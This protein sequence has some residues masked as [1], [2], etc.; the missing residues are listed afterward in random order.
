MKSEVFNKIILAGMSVALLQ[1]SVSC[2]QLDLVETP[3]E[4]MKYELNIQGVINQEYQTRANDEGFVNGDRMGVYVV[5]YEQGVPGA[6]MAEGNRANNMCYTYDGESGNWI[7]AGTLYW[8]D[9][10]TPVDVYGYYP[11]VNVVSSV[12]EYE[13]EVNYN[14]NL[15]ADYGDMSSYEASD[16]LWAKTSGAVY[17]RPI[18]LTYDH[19]MAGVQVVLEKGEGFTD[20]EWIKHT[21][22]ISVDNTIRGSVIDLSS[23]EVKAIGDFDR[24]II[25]SDEGTSYR[26]IVVPQTVAAGKSIIGLTIDGISYN[27]KKEVP[28]TYTSGKLHK[29]TIKVDKRVESGDYMFSLSDEQVLPWEN[30]KSSHNFESRAYVVVHLEKEGTLRQC[31]IDSGADWTTIKNLKI[32]G[33]MTASDFGFINGEMRQLEAINIRDV[34]VFKCDVTAT[35]GREILVDNALP[36]NCFQNMNLLRSVILPTNLEKI[37]G[38]SFSYLRFAT[39][40]VIPDGVREIWEWAFSGFSGELVMPNS[41][42]HIHNGAFSSCQAHTNLVLPPTLKYVGQRAFNNAHGFYGTF[43]LPSSLEYVGPEAFRGCGTDLE[44]SVVIPEKIVSI[45]SQAFCARFKNKTTVTLHSGVKRI[46]G[47]AFAGMGIRTVPVFHE[48]LEYIGDKAFNECYGM[49]GTISFPSTLGY[50]GNGAFAFADLSGVFEIPDHLPIIYSSE[51]RGTFSGNDFSEI[52]STTELLHIGDAAF[53]NNGQLRKVF[54][55]RNVEFIGSKAFS[56]CN[57]IHTFICLAKEP[58]MLG[59]ETFSGLDFEHAILEVPAASV[60][61]YRNTPGWNDFKYITAYHELA[62]GISEITALNAGVER[63]TVLRAEGPWEVLSCPDWCTVT[64]MSGDTKEDIIIRVKDMALGSGDRQGQIVFTLKNKDYTN[65]TSVRQFDYATPE[66]TEVVL[67]EA[68]AGA[69]EIP[70]FILGDGFGAESIKDGSYM[71]IMREQIEHFFNIEPYRTYRNYFT[72]STSIAHSPENGLSTI[73]AL[74]DSR[75]GTVDVN[76]NIS[77]DRNALYDYV[78][79]VSAHIDDRNLQKSLIILMVNDEQ[80]AANVSIE[81]NGTTICFCPLSNESYPYDQRGIIQHYAGGRGFGKLAHEDI[82][83]YDFMQLCSCPGCNKL[84][85]Y[86]WAKERGWYDNVSLSG[87]MSD[88]PWSHLI[89]HEKYSQMVDVY[90]GGLGHARGVF[91]SEINSCMNTFVPYYNTISRESIVRRIMNYAGVEYRFED[92]VARDVVENYQ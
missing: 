64:P 90:E 68:T 3:S 78:K 57:A 41:L 24:N 38:M 21:K 42:E 23:G 49:R 84:G 60:E 66:D 18:T 22:V 46:E 61:L 67:Q 72:V 58:P 17:G 9:K 74:K 44:G 19:L 71:R 52:V 55:E 75:F 31:L 82:Y 69:E 13:F 25:L 26:G 83:H 33:R 20:E 32:T 62:V 79:T 40:L 36:C 47:D 35:D 81:D 85:E 48:G 77:C 14:Q 76:G 88:V 51:A 89:F 5:D 30:D 1:I 87:K 29:F 11:Y 12:H 65:Y 45:N 70:I 80:I 28:L 91:R 37:G 59:N 54:L 86:H 16:F 2:Q 6:L 43:S 53:E 50:L 92:F 73:Q 10:T 56:G 27:L 63:S 7:P 4:D 15:K 8:R 39:Q 34:S